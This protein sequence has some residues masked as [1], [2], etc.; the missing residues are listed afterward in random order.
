MIWYPPLASMTGG[1]SFQRD[2]EDADDGSKPPKKKRATATAE[3]RARHAEEVRWSGFVGV[4]W[5]K[6][7]RK[8]A[9][10][11]R[12]HGKTIYLGYFSN[13]EEAARRYDEHA[14]SLGRPVN[15]PTDASHIQAQKCAP[16][17]PRFPRKMKEEEGQKK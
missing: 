2:D 7:A 17:V 8:W 3:E 1:Q 16:R 11:S 12:V 15:F 14:I 13:E 10:Q 9:T 4:C 5:N 6:R